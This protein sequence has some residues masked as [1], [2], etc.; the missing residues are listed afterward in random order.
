[1]T[2]SINDE[3]LVKKARSGD[4]EAFRLLYQRYGAQIFRFLYRFLGSA[5]IAEDITHDCFMT[6][7]SRD[8]ASESQLA[9]PTRLYLSA[10][11]LAMNHP[12]SNSDVRNNDVHG[13]TSPSV[14]A[15]AV[16]A[17]PPLEREALIF[18]EYEGLEI[19]EIANIVG[20]D[21]DTVAARL[22]SARQ[23]LRSA[24]AMFNEP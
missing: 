15:E 13:G 1:M 22:R 24:L 6:L 2:D 3:V 21:A 16:A 14:V 11:T 8:Q 10:R 7:I 5:G 17:L 23:R 4:H 18:S 12:L 19:E 9:V 20:S